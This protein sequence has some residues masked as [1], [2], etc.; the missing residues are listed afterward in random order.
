MLHNFI[1]N[2]EIK[3]IYFDTI[4]RY[5]FSYVVNEYGSHV[6]AVS[7]FK[8][9]K[10]ISVFVQVERNSLKNKFFAKIGSPSFHFIYIF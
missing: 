3:F 9:I 6:F 8:L 2:I 10:V 5:I 7:K 1:G 4:N